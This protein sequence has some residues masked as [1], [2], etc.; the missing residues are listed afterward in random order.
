MQKLRGKSPAVK[1]L[2]ELEL[3]RENQVLQSSFLLQTHAAFHDAEWLRRWQF[4]AFANSCC[5]STDS[6]AWCL[7]QEDQD[8]DEDQDEDDGDEG[9]DVDVDASEPQ[10]LLHA[11]DM[12]R[13]HHSMRMTECHIDCKGMNS[14]LA[15][16]RLQ[17]KAPSPSPS[18]SRVQSPVRCSCTYACCECLALDALI[19]TAQ[20]EQGS[21]PQVLLHSAH[22]LADVCRSTC[23][24]E[25]CSSSAETMRAT[26]MYAANP[27]MPTFA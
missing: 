19:V 24:C 17:V 11:I 5:S 8:Q 2:S 20:D 4:P 13:P 16:N 21:Q 26:R 14:L 15:T 10:V 6:L 9:E 18:S 1:L 7:L 12:C 23:G 22:D 27:L 3:P 25:P